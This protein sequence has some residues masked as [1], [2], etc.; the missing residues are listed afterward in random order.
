M[1]WPKERRVLGQSTPRLDGPAKVSGTA[2][3]TADQNPPGLCYGVV[4]YAPVGRARITRLDL[5]PARRMPG[6]RAV[7]GQK[8]AGAEIRYHGE[9]VAAVAAESEA[10]ARDAVRAIVLQWEPLEAL[11]TE[12][13]AAAPGAP[14]ILPE[15]N[16]RPADPRL[17]GDVD[18]AMA[19]A[20]VVFEGRFRTRVITHV[21]LEPH[22][23]VAAWQ[24]NKLTVW[25]STQGVSGCR[26]D[27]ARSLQL[28]PADVE[29]VCEYMGGGFGSKLGAFS[30]EMTAA[31]LAREAGRPVKL[32]LDRE[33][34]HTYAGCR[35]SVIADVKLGADRQGNLLALDATT[36]GTGGIAGRGG[37]N[38]PYIYRCGAGRQ[39]HTD[40]AINAGS[41]R[42]MRAPGHPQASFVME[43]AMEGLALKL[44]IDPLE[45]RRRNLPQNGLWPRQLTLG[46][47][48]IGW[49]SR[50][51]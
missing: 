38:L 29:V 15:G 22:G 28:P 31:R 18:A 41:M 40:L 37:I 10:Q 35:R 12:E 3:Y 20:E 13:A 47:E 4:L 7:L 27:L 30:E 24:G 11:V 23:A 51:A 2:R 46:A 43:S 5:D 19:R 25:S 48:R 26:N 42:A 17:R 32:M 14:K 44:G 6:V 49:A 16:A 1:P 9:Y 34:E 21:C 33:M 8:N 36:Q 45:L 50:P 39:L